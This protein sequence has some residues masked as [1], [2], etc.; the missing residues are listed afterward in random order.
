MNNLIELTNKKKF[1]FIKGSILDENLLK[2]L[3]KKE[4][5]DAVINFAA[6]THVDRS[7]ENSS[8]FTSSNVLGVQKLI[9][10]SM[11]LFRENKKFKFIQIST[12]EVFGSITEGSFNELSPYSPNSP[13]AATKASGDHLV[14]AYFKTF[15]FPGIITNCTNNYGKNQFPEKLIPLLIIKA[16]QKKNLPIYG[17]G[18][19]M[20]DWL[21]VNDHCNAIM[22]VLNKGKPGSRYM[23]GGNNCMRNLDI[24][25]KICQIFDN[26]KPLNKMKYEDLIIF[27]KDRPG[28]DLRYS[29]DASKIKIELNWTPKVNF[30]EGL[31]DTIHWY[32]NNKGWW[33]DIQKNSSY[34]GQ[35]IGLI[36]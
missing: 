19:Q 22:E 13:Y 33:E 15:N 5:F 36:S 27:V 30:T 21:H 7:I 31:I 8:N 1:N 3:F 11:I 14:S 25:L 16:L 28:H 32:I 9:D 17:N 4:K 20:R 29:V 18:N 26:I 2:K 35:R 24:A 34:K 23:I 6:E 10:Q 12:D